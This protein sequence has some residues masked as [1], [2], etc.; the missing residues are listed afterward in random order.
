MY[1][2]NYS[3][4]I[5]IATM[6]KLGRKYGERLAISPARKFEIQA[7]ENYYFQNYFTLDSNVIGLSRFT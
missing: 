2:E 4:T 3:I 6:E 1:M 5:S 7:V